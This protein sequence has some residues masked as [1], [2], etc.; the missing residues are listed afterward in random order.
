MTA[1]TGRE[2]HFATVCFTKNETS[3]ESSLLGMTLL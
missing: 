2:I 1:E 3:T